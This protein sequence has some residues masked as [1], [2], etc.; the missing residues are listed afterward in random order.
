MGW[1]LIA[2]N[3]IWAQTP[4][5]NSLGA[6]LATH[7]QAD[8]SRVNRLNALGMAVRGSNPTLQLTTAQ[9]ALQLALRLGYEAGQAQAL[10]N[11]SH[12]AMTSNDYPKA[13]ALAQKAR[14]LYS[15]QNDWLGQ[16]NCLNRLAYIAFDQG[17]Y[18]QSIALIQQAQRLAEPLTD[19]GLKAYSMLLMAQNYVMLDDFANARSYATIGLRLARLANNG[20]EQSR[21]LGVLAT[22]SNKQGKLA[23]ARHYFEQTLSLAD[24]A[25]S[26]I[27]RAIGEGN[28]AEVSARQGQYADAFRYGQRARAYFDQI[29]AASYLPWIEAVLAQTFLDTGQLDSALV[30]GR[31]SLRAA[32]AGGLRDISAEVC[33]MLAGVQA[34][35]GNYQAAYRYQARYTVLRDSLKGE[36]TVR[37]T[38][39]LQRRYD[40]ASQQAKIA[41][42]T[43]NQKIEQERS[44]TQRVL[45]IA[46]LGGLLLLLVLAIVLVRNNKA[47]Q[48][49]NAQLNGQKQALET[50]LTDLRTT[51]T[52]LIHHAKM[53]SLGE[54][55][56][57][58]AHEIQN[59]LNFINNFSDVSLELI[60]EL[61]GEIKA[62]NLEETGFIT[63]DL[64][65]NLERISHHG[66]RA[67][68]IVSG[69]L[70]HA[71]TSRGERQP[72]DLNRLCDDYLSVSH[73][74]S[75]G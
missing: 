62:E 24:Q 72:S 1:L 64:R 12:Q 30:Y 53:A 16:V 75:E 19:Q 63:T 36:E 26:A 32:E 29:R 69:M 55:T 14:Q 57:G 44:R 31:R 58:I 34:R 22:V 4:A 11:L 38:A 39:A 61:T 73:P 37:Q 17:Q 52:Q 25:G 74:E 68:L 9:E 67:G 5:I 6:W 40:Q 50:A 54:L 23:E 20:N 65:Q 8:T 27:D 51:Q 15:H 45:L 49:V 28:I 66:K 43:K 70:D 10:L 21:A 47:K 41:L 46:T 56:A 33:S 7:P 3:G 71:R 48:R 13:T 42:L 60:E 18:P 35:R 59:P 2:A